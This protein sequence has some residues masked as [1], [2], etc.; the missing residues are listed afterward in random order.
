MAVLI[1]ILGLQLRR[2]AEWQLADFIVGLVPGEIV[3]LF[4]S[5]LFSGPALSGMFHRLL[6]IN[7]FIL[8]P[9]GL[10]YGLGTV[11]LT[12]T[13][14]QRSVH[15][16]SWI[17]AT[18]YALCGVGFIVLIPHLRGVYARFAVPLPKTTLF[19]IRLGPDTWFFLA[20][21]LAGI[22]VW[23]DLVLRQ[24]WPNVLFSVLLILV[25]IALFVPLL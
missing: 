6:D 24:R 7:L 5:A 23:K 14:R 22:V 13:Q 18:I 10:G 3:A 1:T 17:L 15:L 9:W 16:R 2:G 12:A 21:A 25:I 4:V 20:L 11:C 19:L 8:L